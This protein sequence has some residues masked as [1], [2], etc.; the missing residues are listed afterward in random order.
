MAKKTGPYGFL[1][2][3]VNYNDLERTIDVALYKHLMDNKLRERDERFQKI[4]SSANDGIILINDQDNITFW[5]QAAEKIF[6]YSEKEVI[7]KNLYNFL[8][9]ANHQNAIKKSFLEYEATS[10][11]NTIGNNLEVTGIKKDG[12]KVIIELSLSSFKEK[13]S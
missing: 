13:N 10:A 12:T 4:S 1:T 11:E 2:K 6:G 8:I 9:P 5:N 7:N 3:P